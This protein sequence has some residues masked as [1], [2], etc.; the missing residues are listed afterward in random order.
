M[1]DTHALIITL[2]E[3]LQ[4]AFI[5]FG[6]FLFVYIF[7]VQPHRVQ[8]VS[9][10]PT[11][12]NGELLL[13]EKVSYRFSG[14]HRGDV[15]VFEAPIERKADFIKRL[16][17]I[18]GD[19]VKIFEGNIYVNSVKVDEKYI[20]GTTE[21]NVTLTL[22]EDEY[23]VLGD[24]RLASSDSRVFG[25]IKR[26]SIRGKVWVVYWPLFKKDNFK[27]LRLVLSIDDRVPQ[28]FKYLG[29]ILHTSLYH[30]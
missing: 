20:L 3:I 8:G 9:M 7:L 21:G 27:G 12:E 18:P 14:P 30:N 19:S 11:F 5:S 24:N 4:T 22:G 10:H 26:K 28:G 1:D 17:A 25:S 23:Y 29:S 13:T 2:K 15:V 16:V 6:I